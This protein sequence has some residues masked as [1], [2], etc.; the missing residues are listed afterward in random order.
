MSSRK[1]KPVVPFEGLPTDGAIRAF[2]ADRGECD[3]SP[4]EMLSSLNIED[5]SK[6]LAKRRRQQHIERTSRKK[7][8][9][10]E[11]LAETERLDSV[12]EQLPFDRTPPSTKRVLDSVVDDSESTTAGAMTVVTNS[13]RPAGSV[14]SVARSISTRSVG[15]CIARHSTAR[16]VQAI[17]KTE[18]VDIVSE[19]SG[20]GAFEYGFLSGAAAAGLTFRLIAASE[21]DCDGHAAAVLQKRFPGCVVCSDF[22][23]S[24]PKSARVLVATPPCVE[25]SG[26]N[27]KRTPEKTEALVEKIVQRLRCSP[28]IEVVILENVLN[29]GYMLDGQ[30]CSSYST[31]VSD[32]TEIG[33]CEHGYVSLPT[34]VSGDLHSRM[35]LLSVSTRGR[36][37]RPAAALSRLL[38]SEPDVAEADRPSD[39]D[40]DRSKRRKDDASVLAFNTGLS[41]TRFSCKERVQMVQERLPA[42]SQ[43]LNVGLFMH[44]RGTFHKLSPSLAAACSGLPAEYQNVRHGKAGLKKTP[45]HVELSLALANMVSPLQAYTL[46]HAIASEWIDPH[47]PGDGDDILR[48]ATLIYS[49]QN[50]GGVPDAFC[51]LGDCGRGTFGFCNTLASF[52][53][54]SSSRWFELRKPEW[55]RSRPEQTLHQLCTQALKRGDLPLLT[56]LTDLERVH[57]DDTL[58]QRVRNCAKRQYEKCEAQQHA[59]ERRAIQ[60]GR[61]SAERRRLQDTWVQCDR[62]GKWRRLA[63]WA[64]QIDARSQAPQWWV[65]GA[66]AEAPYDH[67]DAPQEDEAAEPMAFAPPFFSRECDRQLQRSSVVG[68]NGQG[69]LGGAMFSGQDLKRALTRAAVSDPGTGLLFDS[70]VRSRRGSELIERQR[71]VI[72]ENLSAQEAG[73]RAAV[74]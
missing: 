5:A 51:L 59:D 28:W 46:G 1:R 16:T 42:Y 3:R 29:F 6:A 31:W 68:D 37:F 73:A 52:S 35:R 70:L 14:G 71:D 23:S 34:C 57:D 60:E 63:T 62:C 27:A 69:E 9:A 36:S 56:S 41:Q 18:V 22:G 40:V 4:G 13:G 39:D 30:D 61:A 21:L 2:L 43:S 44:R 10:I 20:I 50:V 53:S 47:H 7:L 58:P 38:L 17:P 19:C 15:H 64:Q 67:C 12:P 24:Y 54:R 48:S 32:I 33:F 25:H 11:A 72:R 66:D 55:I 49:R 45:T 26:L 8:Q 65:C 74:S